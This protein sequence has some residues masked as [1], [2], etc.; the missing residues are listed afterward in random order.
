MNMLRSGMVISL[1]FESPLLNSEGTEGIGQA[2]FASYL[3]RF[4]KFFKPQFPHLRDERINYHKD[5]K[6]GVYKHINNE[7]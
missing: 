6:T 1:N 7:G 4:Y 2:T 3:G 5:I